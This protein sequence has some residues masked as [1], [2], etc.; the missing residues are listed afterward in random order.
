MSDVPFLISPKKML[1]L[2]KVIDFF[3]DDTGFGD[4]K[5][6]KLFKAKAKTDLD[7]LNIFT[8][9]PVFEDSSKSMFKSILEDYSL[10]GIINYIKTLP[11]IKYIRLDKLLELINIVIFIKSLIII[12]PLLIIYWK[13]K[14]DVNI[15]FNSIK[16]FL[17]LDTSEN[18]R[19][20]FNGVVPNIGIVILPV[21]LIMIIIFAVRDP[22]SLTDNTI[23]YAI[24]MG[25]LIFGCFI[26][27][28]SLMK[29][30]TANA[31][32][33]MPMIVFALFLIGMV[34]S[35][36]ISSFVSPYITTKSVSIV[37]NALRL[38]LVL[39][40]IIGLAIGYKFYSE[41]LK[42]LTG[43]QGFF[44]NFLFYIP[45]LISD[46]LEYLLQQYNI[47]PNI[48]FVL[49]II[50]LLLALSYFYL[51]KLLN[52][53]IKKTEIV[54]QNKPVYLNYETVVGNTEMFL[55]KPINVDEK[56]EYIPQNSLY[57][58]NYCISMWVFLNVHSSS[59][60][61][62]KN[63]TEIFD[64]SSHPRITYKNV[65]NNPKS[66]DK[67]IYTFYFSNTKSATIEPDEDGKYELSLPNQKWN[68][69]SFN[70]FDTKVDLYINGNL[71]RTY[72]F[73]DNIPQYSPED[74]VKLGKENGLNGAICNVSY[75]KKPLTSTE[76]ST[77]YNINYM[78][79][80]PISFIE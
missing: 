62:Y 14:E 61:A 37:S 44:I 24:L 21:I 13:F 65:S 69:I 27:F 48:V 20:V 60:S 46:G 5:I 12:I 32:A 39:M 16:S 35:T 70:Y 28:S 1:G 52:K 29:A 45:C 79:N 41:R 77:A 11:F 80:P 49:L 40:L 9:K 74:L 36:Y 67:G 17:H 68:L 2:D 53:S 50:E 22:S 76:I 78:N 19:A 51:P 33:Y 47:T 43:W 63:E 54:L 34:V 59:T 4:L 30:S 55:F 64:Y 66:K 58:R 71:E 18:R 57:R 26:V 31:S 8:S 75:N 7:N 3:T 25:G 23:I 10:F 73:S 38:I 42:A 56:I 15:I 6:P 72:T